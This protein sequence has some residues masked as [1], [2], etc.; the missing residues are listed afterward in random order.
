MMTILLNVSSA[1]KGYIK[2][3]VIKVIYVVYIY[4]VL[5]FFTVE[6]FYQI[7]QTALFQGTKNH[8]SYNNYYK[9][10]LKFTKG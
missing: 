10:L 9:N 3:V 2:S 5:Y 1:F 6:F 8:I 4:Y 7:L